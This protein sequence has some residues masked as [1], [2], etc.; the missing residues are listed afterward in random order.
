LENQ[1]AGDALRDMRDETGA[2]S[3]PVCA[4]VSTLFRDRAVNAACEGAGTQTIARESQDAKAKIE[5]K[6][7]AAIEAGESTSMTARDWKRIKAEGL[8][9]LKTEK[10]RRT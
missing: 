1:D 8:K 9:R 3:D 2:C 6:L 4:A 7:L 5:S 10:K